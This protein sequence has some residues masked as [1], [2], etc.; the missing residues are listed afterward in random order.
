MRWVPVAAIGL[1]AVLLVAA[2]VVAA[3]SGGGSGEAAPLASR[4]NAPAP[5]KSSAP[6]SSAAPSLSF[7]VRASSADQRCAS[8]AFGDV[9]ASL[10]QTSCSA[11][12]RA[13]YTALVDGRPAAVTVAVVEF[14]DGEQATNFKRVADNPG[15]GGIL[16]VAT[17]TGKWSGPPPQF[18][19]AA[20]ASK[21]EGNGVRLVQAVWQTG[22]STPGDPGLTRAAQGA[23]DLAMPS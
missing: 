19:N 12:R 4:A 15:G 21:L 18:D 2:I 13:S 20:Y 9:Q 7:E 1:L 16:D 5:A 6:V 11:V 10:Q 17:E 23:L 3:T 14:P 8:H 22:P